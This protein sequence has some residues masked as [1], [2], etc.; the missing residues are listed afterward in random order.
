MFRSDLNSLF[1][2]LVKKAISIKIQQLKKYN[3]KKIILRY[4]R[5][6]LLF[7]FR[8]LCPFVFKI[9]VR[10]IIEV[11]RKISTQNCSTSCSSFNFSQLHKVHFPLLAQ[12][13]MEPKPKHRASNTGTTN[14]QLWL[15]IAPWT[16]LCLCAYHEQ[17]I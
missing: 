9:L 10:N 16:P 11:K 5:F 12:W 13:Q 6:F 2:R 7:M 14:K 17:C 1:L 4:I 3:C 8:N 15:L